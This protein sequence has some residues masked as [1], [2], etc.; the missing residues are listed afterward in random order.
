MTHAKHGST[1][2]ASRSQGKRD[3]AR[4]PDLSRKTMRV[5]ILTNL[6]HP[7]TTGSATHAGELARQLVERGHEVV[8][9]TPKLDEQSPSHEIVEGVNVYRVRALRLPRH[10]IALNFPWLNWTLWPRNVRRVRSILEDHGTEI[11]HVHNHMFDL[12]LTASYLRRKMGIPVVLTLHTVIKHSQRLFNAILYPADRIVLRR[13]VVRRADAVI[14]PDVNIHN[15]LQAAFGRSDGHLIP[16]G[17]T[18]PSH[19][20]ID[21]EQEIRSTHG[22]DGRKVILSLGH[23]HALRNRLDL[24]RAISLVREVVPEVLLLVVGSI[25][26]PRAQRLVETLGLSDHV[27]FTGQQSHRRV[28]AFHEIATVEAMWLD[29]DNAGLNSLGIACMEGMMV[30]RP[31]MAIA[32]PDTFG[33]GVLKDGEH[34]IIL[35]NRDVDLIADRLIEVLTNE[36]IADEVGRNARE[37]AIRHFSWPQVADNIEGVYTK[38]VAVATE[39]RAGTS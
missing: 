38:V 10:A 8:V 34:A 7:V 33:P 9:V 13:L 35:R 31:V 14:C 22:L 19:P 21:V 37:F 12:A 11:I 1:G 25:G 28:R 2:S 18:L 4:N 23:L 3:L 36:A 26:D 6:F 39:V 15:Y 17:I 30:G 16:Y 29:Q 27:V 5:A 20:G 32:N 24:I